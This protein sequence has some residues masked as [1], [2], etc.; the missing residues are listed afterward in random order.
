MITLN[1]IPPAKK[2]ELKLMNFYIIIKNLVIWVLLLSILIAI[3]L[4][5]TKAVLQSH[6][7][8]IVDQTTLTTRYATTFGQEVKEFNSRIKTVAGIQAENISWARFLVELALLVPDK[9]SVN[10]LTIKDDNILLNGLAETR[11][12]L[13]NLQDSMENSDLFSAVDIPLDNLLKKED[14]SFT[15]KAK[16]NLE[17]L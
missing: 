3:T 7:N 8:Q 16:I 12:D 13:L 1:L 15:L 11:D 6:F 2:Q 14:V 10:N 9:I 4:L 5:M 17:I